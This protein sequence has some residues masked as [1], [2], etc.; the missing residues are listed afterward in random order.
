[1]TVI[2]RNAGSPIYPTLAAALLGN[3]NIGQMPI[4]L[5]DASELDGLGKIYIVKANGSGGTAMANGNELLAY[6]GTAATKDQGTAQTELGLNSYRDTRLA[7]QVHGGQFMTYDGSA[8]AITLTSVNTVPLPAL[9][10]GDSFT[11][12][13]TTTNTGAAT[14]NIDGIGVLTCKTKTGAALPA[15][16]FRIDVNTRF[17]YDGTDVI[18]SR[19]VES[20]S[21][22]NGSFTRWEDGRQTCCRTDV[23]NESIANVSGAI[24]VS[25]G[26]FG[27]DD[28]ASPFVGSVPVTSIDV[29]A[30]SNSSFWLA[31]NA[32]VPTLTKFGQHRLAESVS[33]VAEN[34]T[35]R[36]TAVGFW[37]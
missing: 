9:Q 24:F 17:D 20:G 37:Y 4:V 28:Y 13:I 27:D 15:G 34:Y 30:S 23:Y 29:S 11:A 8:D 25:A 14:V 18:V 5:G 12:R 2:N 22:A 33:T 21:N 3:L 36:Q 19:A 31:N 16:Y 35:A 10:T 7:K 6:T 1:M 26:T 32:V